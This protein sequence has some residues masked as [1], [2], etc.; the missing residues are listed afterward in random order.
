M[1]ETRSR[2]T[3]NRPRR[4]VEPVQR[5]APPADVGQARIAGG[6]AGSRLC[7]PCVGVRA[8]PL[9]M[10][11]PR[12]CRQTYA[13][14]SSRQAGRQRFAGAEWAAARDAFAAALEE[15]PGDPEALD[16]LGQSLWWLGE[17][18]VAL[19][20]EAMTVALGGETSDPMAC[21]D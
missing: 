20:D 15:E 19:L 8:H 4:G 21:G 14:M 9:P 7:V 2:G 5:T 6:A 17:E 12:S 13:D 1:H 18:G 11:R 16:G 3:R 10:R